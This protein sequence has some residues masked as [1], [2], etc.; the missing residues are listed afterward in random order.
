[1]DPQQAIANP[2]AAPTPQAAT[3]Q[4]QSID[5]PFE[6]PAQQQVSTQSTQQ[7]PYGQQQLPNGTASASPGGVLGWL[8]DLETDFRHGTER[9]AVGK[10]LNAIGAKPNAGDTP[11]G[12]FVES[13][14]LGAMHAAQGVAEMPQHPARGALHAVEG[15]GEMATIPAFAAGAPEVA[16]AAD[17]APGLLSKAASSLTPQFVK[18]TVQG[19]KQVARP[20]TDAVGSA[21]DTL[22][23]VAQKFYVPQAIKDAAAAGSNPDTIAAAERSVEDINKSALPELHSKIGKVIDAA[24][25]A[26]GHDTTSAPSL[27]AKL[28]SGGMEYKNQAQALYKQADEIAA[29][30]TGEKGAFQRLG[31]AVEDAKIALQN[32]ALTNDEKIAAVER[33]TNSQKAYS[34]YQNLAA[35]KGVNVDAITGKANKLYSTGLSMEEFGRRVLG[36]ENVAGDLMASRRPLNN[37]VKQVAVK[38]GGNRG[39]VLGQALGEDGAAKVTGAVTDAENAIGAARAA[40]ASATSAVRSGARAE[41]QIAATRKRQ[42]VGGAALTGL[43]GVGGYAAHSLYG[44]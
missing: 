28:A 5:N 36:S 27:T 4:P 33:L 44:K 35:Q 11:A 23:N 42:V 9:T 14:P 1:M 41:K 25:A 3:P 15:A 43:S 40:K 39:H 2:F 13:V 30:A 12:N 17:A 10:V 22:K 34:D 37:A 19:V 29:Q 8:H 31:Q 21:T 16:Q 38:V 24:N 18:D 26:I 7:D 20:L 6:A 32:T